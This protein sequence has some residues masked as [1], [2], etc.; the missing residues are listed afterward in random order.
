[1]TL[2]CKAPRERM[3]TTSAANDKYLHS[4]T[5]SLAGRGPV[6]LDTPFGTLE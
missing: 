3:F 5:D 6:P 2:L 1:M 4:R